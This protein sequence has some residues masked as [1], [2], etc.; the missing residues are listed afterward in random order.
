VE[1]AEAMVLLKELVIVQEISRNLPTT[2][3]EIVSM[4]AMEMV[5]V[6]NWNL[7]DVWILML[8]TMMQRQQL[9]MELVNTVD[10]P[11]QVL[12]ILIHHGSI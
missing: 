3:K 11:F 8:G 9:M 2:A 10:A 7:Q 6:M 5:F 1:F 12:V 4:T